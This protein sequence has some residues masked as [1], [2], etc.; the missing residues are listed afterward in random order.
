V[1][2]VVPC[3]ICKQPYRASDLSTVVV[4]PP[5]YE[6]L[7]EPTARNFV[8]YRSEDRAEKQIRLHYC[9]LCLDHLELPP[10]EPV[11]DPS[12]APEP[13]HPGEDV[14]GEGGGADE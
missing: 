13:Y 12:V 6:D 11:S 10:V 7:P 14:G 2:F 5:H 9:E 3:D 4:D 8:A 1:T